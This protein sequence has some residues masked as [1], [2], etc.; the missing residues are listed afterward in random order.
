MAAAAKIE[1]RVPPSAWFRME[2]VTQIFGITADAAKK[3]RIRG[4]WLEGKHYRKDPANR[5]V[6]NRAAIEAWMA[7]ND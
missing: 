2:V 4:L 1:Y 6:Y 7:G 5:I 3:Y